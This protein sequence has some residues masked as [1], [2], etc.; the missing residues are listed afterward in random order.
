MVTTSML[1]DLQI[2]DMFPMVVL[3]VRKR[4]VEDWLQVHKGLLSWCRG[5]EI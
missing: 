5:G 3:V 4:L 2:L 1:G